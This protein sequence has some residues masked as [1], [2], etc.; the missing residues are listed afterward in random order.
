LIVARDIHAKI[1]VIR[2][3]KTNAEYLKPSCLLCWSKTQTGM[4]SGS[5][6]PT[7]A[8]RLDV[9]VEEFKNRAEA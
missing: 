3:W 9:Y 5:F 7:T 2:C 6:G 1:K 8:G 4:P